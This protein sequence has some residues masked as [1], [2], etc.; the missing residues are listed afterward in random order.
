MPEKDFKEIIRVMRN[1]LIGGIIALF[2]TISTTMTVFYFN[3]KNK[4]QDHD[5][6]IEKLEQGCAQKENIDIKLNYISNQI[7][8][9]KVDIRDIKKNR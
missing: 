6:R 3:S 5:I 4:L 2:F 9:I 7:E 8:E 1:Y